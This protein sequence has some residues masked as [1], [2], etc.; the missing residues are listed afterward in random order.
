MSPY[1]ISSVVIQKLSGG[2][3]SKASESVV[4]AKVKKI[5]GLV[6]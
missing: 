6:V 5:V 3:N 2:S 4:E 1:N